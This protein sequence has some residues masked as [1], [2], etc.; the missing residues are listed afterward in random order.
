MEHTEKQRHSL[1]PWKAPFRPPLWLL[2]YCRE[3]PTV[4]RTSSIAVNQLR[5]PDSPEKGDGAS[6]VRGRQQFG[7]T[8]DVPRSADRHETGDSLG[9]S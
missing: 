2:V 3:A 9:L 4:E 8:I 5:W 7:C 1:A 6:Q